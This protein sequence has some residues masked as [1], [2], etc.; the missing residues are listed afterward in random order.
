[1]SFT[2][3]LLLEDMYKLGFKGDVVRV[4]NGY[5]RNFLVP[6]HKARI[7]DKSTIVLQEKLR[8]ERRQQ[9]EAERKADQELMAK[10]ND[11]LI[12]VSANA[13]EDSKLYGSISAQDIAQ[14]LSEQHQVEL[15]K[16]AIQ[17]EEPIKALGVF[18][19]EVRLREEVEGSIRVKVIAQTQEDQ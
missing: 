2:Q 12:T 14:L 13:D 6:Q 11:K 16:K 8:D 5:A 1:M 17:L 10:I 7:A 9:L 15:P 18:Q 4:K 3:V 19:V